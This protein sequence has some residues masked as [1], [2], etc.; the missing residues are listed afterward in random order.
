MDNKNILQRT[1]DAV[2]G[3]LNIEKNALLGIAAEAVYAAILMMT[4]LAVALI[5]TLVNKL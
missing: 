5:I 4:A 3:I 1:V 2:F